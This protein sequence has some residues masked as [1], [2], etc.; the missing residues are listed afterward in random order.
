MNPDTCHRFASNHNLITGTTPM[1]LFDSLRSLRTIGNAFLALCLACALPSQPA[2]AQAPPVIADTVPAVPTVAPSGPTPR[3]SAYLAAPPEMRVS[4]VESIGEEGARQFARRL[5]WQPVCD[6]LTARQVQGFDQVWMDA[7]GAVHVVEAKGGGSSLGRGYGFKQG[8]PEWAVSAAERTLLNPRATTLEKEAARQIL[9]AAKSG[10]LHVHVMRT[11]H[12][13][14]EPGM[15]VVEQSQK[16]TIHARRLAEAAS[17]RMVSAARE[18]SRAAGPVTSANLIRGSFTASTSGALGTPARGGTPTRSVIAPRGPWSPPTSPTTKVPR[19]FAAG[20][21]LGV[22]LAIDGAVRVADS[23]E[24]ERQ[25]QSGNMDFVQRRVAHARN[26][27][28]MAGGWATAS[29]GAW[30]G[31]KAGAV[32]GTAVLPGVGTAI[33]GFV[34]GL[35]GGAGGYII[36]DQVGGDV[37]AS[38]AAD[39][40]RP[41]PGLTLPRF[42]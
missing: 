9:E 32:A 4:Y 24:I 30:V 37:A 42:K 25:Y 22:G 40:G 36:G 20:A 27:G 33:G 13:L 16:G 19:G 18:A 8:T 21:L 15:T 26:W 3:Q 1:T 10:R 7:D 35:A 23:A 31:A 38:I 34:G 17:R 41:V 11:P 28:G 14:G 39:A 6:G 2:L 12:V 29:G 5:G